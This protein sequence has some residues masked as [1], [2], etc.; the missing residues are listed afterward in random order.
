MKNMMLINSSWKSGKTFKMIPT[1]E[2]CPFVECI[3]DQELKVL[4]VI[5]Y[6]K[7]DTFHMVEKVDANGDP[8]LRKTPR[9]DGNPFKQERRTLET[10]QE[11]YLENREDIVSFVDMFAVNASSFNIEEHLNAVVEATE[12]ITAKEV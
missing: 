8:E 11:Y 7:K 5:G 10:Y 1:T 12:Q 9:K 4:A 6:H 3:Y 2:D